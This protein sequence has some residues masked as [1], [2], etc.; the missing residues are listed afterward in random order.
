MENSIKFWFSNAMPVSV[1]SPK[2]NN[3]K[4]PFAEVSCFSPKFASPLW[5]RPHLMTA[6]CRVQRHGQVAWIHNLEV[7][8]LSAGWPTSNDFSVKGTKTWPPYLDSQLER[9]RPPLELPVALAKVFVAG[10]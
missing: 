9:T 7:P 1:L 3:Q 6:P 8:G 5:D 2:Q 10:T 4:L